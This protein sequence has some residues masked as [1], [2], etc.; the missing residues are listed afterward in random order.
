M[1]LRSGWLQ[2]G[3]AVLPMTSGAACGNNGG[4]SLFME[5][6]PTDRLELKQMLP[7]HSQVRW[8]TTWTLLGHHAALVGSARC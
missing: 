1:G 4:W 7:R 2:S 6:K 8:Q 3:W 5:S